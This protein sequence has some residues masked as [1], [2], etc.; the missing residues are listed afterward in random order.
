MR[1]K[2]GL[3]ALCMHPTFLSNTCTGDSANER[4]V[5]L[6]RRSASAPFCQAKGAVDP[7]APAP[8]LCACIICYTV[9]RSCGTVLWVHLL[10]ESRSPATLDSACTA[11][12]QYFNGCRRSA[13]TPPASQTPAGRPP[14]CRSAA[15]AQHPRRGPTRWHSCT[16]HKGRAQHCQLQACPKAG[17]HNTHVK[18]SAIREEGCITGG[19]E[20]AQR[21]DCLFLHHMPGATPPTCSTPQHRTAGS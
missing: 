16:Q 11:N 4:C 18:A 15:S 17:Q 2:P 12:P 7:C 14:P 21:I 3:N 8:V 6:M 5:D 10:L 19:R 1:E 13:C 20:A 9:E